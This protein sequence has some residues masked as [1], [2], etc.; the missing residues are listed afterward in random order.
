MFGVVPQAMIGWDWPE[1]VLRG[2]VLGLAFAGVHRW[3]ARRSASLWATTFYVFLCLWSYFTVRSTT[4]HILLYVVYG[5]LPALVLLVAARAA[6][7]R[8]WARDATASP[9]PAMLRPSGD[10]SAMAARLMALGRVYFFPNE[11]TSTTKPTA[12]PATTAVPP[13]AGAATPTP[14][15][16]TAP[17]PAESPP[18]NPI[19]FKTVLPSGAGDIRSAA[20]ALGA[21]VRRRLGGRRARS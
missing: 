14:T 17:P 16:A 1:L 21:S 3:Y 7:V 20:G 8:L 6:L 12:R 13:T 2:G 11:L 4:F 19:F 9:A 5:F 10:A 18:H 15:A